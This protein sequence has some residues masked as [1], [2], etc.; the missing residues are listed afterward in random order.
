M[1]SGTRTVR[2]LDQLRRQISDWRAQGLRTALVPTMGSLHEGHLTLVRQGLRLADHVVVTIFINPKQF[3]PGEDLDRYPRD[4]KGDSRKLKQAGASLI[5][6]PDLS[7][8]YPEGF[9]TTVSVAGPAKVKLEDKYRPHF[10][11]GVAT[12]VSKLFIQTGC[13]YAMFGEKDYQQLKVI[14]RMARDLDIT[15]AI[16]GV[17]TVREPDGLA[18]SSRNTYLSTAERSV[19]PLLHQ[20]LADTAGAILEGKAPARA[21]ASARRR[22]IRAGFKIDYFTARNAETLETIRSPNE[23]VRLLAAVWLGTTRLID[24]I[25]V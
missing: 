10:F 1:R 24:N 3:A 17:E 23:P 8:M 11:N 13:D 2:A 12:I 6:I 16:I 9:A 25:G 15:T 21:T 22:L 20:C 7:L 14:T 19:A 5:F 18:M 4:E